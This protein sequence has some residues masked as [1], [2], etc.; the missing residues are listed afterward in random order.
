VKN[1]VGL[2]ECLTY[3]DILLRPQYSEV[4]PTQTKLDTKL[5][6][7]IAL[8]IPIV[9]SAMD[10]VT[11]GDMAI[12]M[13]KCGGIGV[14][15]KNLD[16]KDQVA[17]LLKVKQQKLT[18]EEKVEATID[19]QGCLRVAAAMGV[20]DKE[21]ERAK[22][23]VKNGIDAVVIDTA[24]G[25]SLGVINMVK[26][27]KKEFGSK[28]DVIAGNVATP[29]ACDDLIKAGVD[30]IKV[31]IG[32]GSIC[33]TRIVAGIGVPQVSAINQCFDVCK[34][35]DTPFI[36]DGGIK[37]SG[38]IVKALGLGAYTVMVGS[39]LAGCTESPGELVQINGQ[40]Y[41]NYRG[42][43]SIGAMER[44]SKDRYGQ[45]EIKEVA[46]LVPEGVEGIV[47]YRGDAREI[48]YQLLGGIRS[49]MG[50]VGAENIDQLKV[51]AS[52][53]RI[54]KASYKESHAHDIIITKEP[55][56]YKNLK[57]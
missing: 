41:K 39:L 5:S 14:I 31:G 57:E 7:N 20:S 19:D 23:L 38:D 43:G 30:G 17:E 33:T 46:K 13:A 54:S 27:L 3:D 12:A 36:A 51:R 56:N 26:R 28:V 32:P 4:L 2:H 8:K 52:F 47:A 1:L 55:P 42:M 40:K 6:R 53:I 16:P 22:L 44:G 29:E 21:Y 48:I 37:F 18:D 15:H 50:Y 25:H 11:E 49:G 34:L 45:G 9:S 35:S 24:H 10:T